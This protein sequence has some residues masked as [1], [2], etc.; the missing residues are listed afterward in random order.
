VLALLRAQVVL[1]SASLRDNSLQ[2]AKSWVD[3]DPIRICS[4]ASTAVTGSTAAADA[5]D[6]EQEDGEG[7]AAAA[8][9]SQGQSQWAQMLPDTITH[10][11]RKRFFL[12]SD[13]WWVTKQGA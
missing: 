6:S 9:G 2:Q 4:E 10:Q 7:A 5:G 3:C 12:I 1:V 8:A 13:R 11:V